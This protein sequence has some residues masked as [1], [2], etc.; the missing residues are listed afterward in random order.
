M[1][2]RKPPRVPTEL[3]HL[4]DELRLEVLSHSDA[5]TRNNLT[6]ADRDWFR[7]RT[8]QFIGQLLRDAEAERSQ[9]W[10]AIFHL[11]AWANL[12][13]VARNSRWAQ[14][15]I[16]K[17]FR[18][19]PC[20]TCFQRVC[21]LRPIGLYDW[22]GNLH[23]DWRVYDRCRPEQTMSRT[24]GAEKSS[25]GLLG[26]SLFRIFPIAYWAR[27]SGFMG[28]FGTGRRTLAIEDGNAGDPG[29]RGDA[30]G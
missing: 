15:M 23:Q 13:A 28:R 12:H 5:E 4:P 14:G 1:L 24:Y 2:C 18:A 16:Y 10:N 11:R 3:S 22:P 29:A 8:P 27:L 9:M 21:I 19:S 6:L 26:G 17:Y 7:F 25:S 20:L 30:G